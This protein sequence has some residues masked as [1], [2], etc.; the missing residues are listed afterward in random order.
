MLPFEP[1]SAKVQKA[2]WILLL[3]FSR[4]IPSIGHTLPFWFF[5]SWHEVG[6][7]LKPLDDCSSSRFS[8]EVDDNL[9][10][11]II[12]LFRCCNCSSCCNFAVFNFSFSASRS[13]NFLVHLSYLNIKFKKESID[14]YYKYNFFIVTFSS[15]KTSTLLRI[16]SILVC[17]LFNRSINF[18]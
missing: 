6:G 4:W 12:W 3:I 13:P 9:G 7:L 15:S 11:D 10:C 16:V 5:N 14:K 8:V 2:A 18:T 1:S 17:I